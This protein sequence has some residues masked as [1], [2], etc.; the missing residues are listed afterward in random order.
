MKT[1]LN[2]KFYHLF[3]NMSSNVNMSLK[4]G[5]GFRELTS[6]ELQL[7]CSNQTSVTPS[8]I[9]V[10][11]A[12]FDL[13]K[14]VSNSLSQRVYFSGCYYLDQSTS[15]WSSYGTEV[16]ADSNITHTHCISTHLTQFAG[17]LVIVPTEINFNKVW[18]NASFT[19]NMTIYLTVII[20]SSLYI[21]LLVWCGIMDRRDD[22]RSQIFLLKD[23]FPIDQYFY[24]LIVFTGNRKD[25]GTDSKVSFILAGSEYETEERELVVLHEESKFNKILQRGSVQ[26]FIMATRE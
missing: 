4:I 24:E 22:K 6:Q 17:G 5:Y 16:L 19:R 23:N 13:T 7:Y 1:E 2:E 9:P 26:S 25:A 20:I 3:A 11:D 12:T 21:G 10:L 8:L 18:S 14:I 15:D